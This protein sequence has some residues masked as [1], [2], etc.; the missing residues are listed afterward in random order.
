M[1]GARVCRDS[2]HKW[3]AYACLLRWLLQQVAGCCQTEPKKSEKFVWLHTRLSASCT[4]AEIFG[5]MCTTESL[6]SRLG[7][8][9][10]CGNAL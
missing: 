5:R 2:I 7:D 9:L 8:L 4:S 3:N 1:D 10:M 6:N